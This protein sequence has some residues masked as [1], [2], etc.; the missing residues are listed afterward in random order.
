MNGEQKVKRL[1]ALFKQKNSLLTLLNELDHELESLLSQ[2]KPS[3]ENKEDDNF[4][5]DPADVWAH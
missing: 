2:P 5:G 3:E 1:E 4:S